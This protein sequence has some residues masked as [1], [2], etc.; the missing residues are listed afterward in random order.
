[1]R[2]PAGTEASSQARAWFPAEVTPYGPGWRC[3]APGKGLINVGYQGGGYRWWLQT[4]PARGMEGRA[5]FA[6][7]HDAMQD[8]ARVT[9]RL[10]PG[11]FAALTRDELFALYREL[12]Q[13]Y[14]QHPGGSRAGERWYTELSG[15]SGEVFRQMEIMALDPQYSGPQPLEFAQA[16]RL[17][18]TGA[19]LQAMATSRNR[20]SWP[21]PPTARREPGRAARRRP[22]ASARTAAGARPARSR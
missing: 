19:A 20:P 15:V 9:D 16:T 8:A 21:T 17:A 5:G 7:P 11:M 2:G 3:Y 4:G 22:A 13:A 18:F 6:D 10:A 1:V 14:P 12:A